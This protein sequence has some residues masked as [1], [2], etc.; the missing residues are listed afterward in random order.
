[1]KCPL[2]GAWSVVRETREA[3][4]KVR[5]RRECGN[6][7][8]F[9]TLETTTNTRGRPQKFSRN[10]QMQEAYDRLKNYSAVGRL[11]GISDNAV[12]SALQSLK[13]LGA[14]E[15]QPRKTK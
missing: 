14:S 8:R 1:M 3:D 11:F 9:W 10:Q 12:R 6:E 5:R 7:H 4:G 2:C 13:R 15:K